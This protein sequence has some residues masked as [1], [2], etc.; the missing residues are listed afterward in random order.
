MRPFLPLV[1][2]GLVATPG[3]AGAKK[4][5]KL[6][7]PTET[8]AARA[9]R[10]ALADDVGQRKDAEL[11]A[12]V[13]VNGEVPNADPVGPEH[14]PP[15]ENNATAQPV[16]PAGSLTGALEEL[17][18]RQLGRNAA[19][20]G[21]LDRCLGEAKKRDGKLLGVD[22]VIKVADKNA[23]FEAVDPALNTCLAGVKGL[24]L[25]MPDQ[26]FTWHFS[27]S[28]TDHREMATR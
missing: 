16:R 11:H 20:A 21:Q 5:P 24:R 12:P 25:S 8:A 13:M 15:A 26:A 18:A 7:T 14:A 17:V 23:A 28:P 6:E 3:I 9:A 19:V 10:L 4:K 1:L 22:V 2:W 27:L